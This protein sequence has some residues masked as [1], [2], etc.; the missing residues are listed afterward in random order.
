MDIRPYE[1]NAKKHPKSQVKLIASSLRDFGW[2]QPIKVGKDGIILVGHGRFQAYNEYKDEFGLKEPWIINESGETVSGG[3]EMR[4]LTALEEKRYRLA[5]NKISESDWDLDLLLPELKEIHELGGDIGLTGFSRD[6]IIL[7]PEERDDIIPKPPKDLQTSLGDIYELGGGHRIMCGDSMDLE[8]VERL[9]N[10]QTADM[11]FSSPP[12][13]IGKGKMYENYE[14][15]RKD[16]D[17]INFQITVL[18]NFVA[19]LRGVVFWNVSYNK[20]NKGY[21]ID[22]LHAIVHKTPLTMRELISWDKGHAMP[23]TP[24]TN[25]TRQQEQILLMENE[26][27]E[28]EVGWIACMDNDPHKQFFKKT[29]KG[30]SNYWR[31]GTNNIQLDNHKACFPV[32]LP[33]K[34]IILSTKE[35]EIVQDP[36]IGSGSTLIACEKSKRVCYAMELDPSYIDITIQRWVDYTGIETVKKNGEDITWKKTEKI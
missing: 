2:Q 29:Q 21:Y 15:D 4:Q 30:I 12:Y 28:G 27:D 6:L 5:D 33:V 17:Y 34:G 36:F 32:M 3:P 31:V 13:N 9:M 14:D 35:G 22:L 18:N 26:G 11:L 10:N 16:H 25:L 24:K 1:N 23:I 20:N 7:N 19:F 8:S